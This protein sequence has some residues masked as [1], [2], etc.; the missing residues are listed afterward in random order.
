MGRE[1]GKEGSHTPL[2]RPWKVSFISTQCGLRGCSLKS[3]SP[4]LPA[5]T[6]IGFFFESLGGNGAGR[7]DTHRATTRPGIT[8]PSGVRAGLGGSQGA[9]RLAEPPHAALGRLQFASG[10]AAVNS[11]DHLTCSSLKEGMFSVLITVPSTQSAKSVNN[12]GDF[13]S[14]PVLPFPHQHLDPTTL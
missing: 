9:R 6:I 10:S 13:P 14:L 11:S 1:A 8:H 12:E 2:H 3:A 5:S 7:A 4:A